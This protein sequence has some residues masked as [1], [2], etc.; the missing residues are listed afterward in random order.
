MT[1]ADKLTDWGFY[2]MQASSLVP[3]AVLARRWRRV[4]AHLR[5]LVWYLLLSVG[6]SVAGDVLFWLREHGYFREYTTYGSNQLFT[7]GKVVFFG[8]MYWYAFQGP[9][10]RRL[11]ALLPAL[12]FCFFLAYWLGPDTVYYKALVMD[13]TQP[14]SLAMLAALALLYLDEFLNYPYKRAIKR[15]PVALISIGHLVFVGGTIVADSFTFLHTAK[16]QADLLPGYVL[17]IIFGTVFNYFLTLALLRAR[18]TA[19]AAAAVSAP[20]RAFAFDYQ[21]AAPAPSATP[22]AEPG[23][24]PPVSAPLDKLG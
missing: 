21:P 12:L 2:I 19:A 10:R 5:L 4:P 6:C 18:P 22:L 17:T 11:S 9:K 23:T 16:T 24:H 1:L 20:P 3:L 13:I 15:D 8:W 14:L 7:V